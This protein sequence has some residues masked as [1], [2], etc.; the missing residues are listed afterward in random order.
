MQRR[1]S[2]FA[3]VSGVAAIATMGVGCASTINHEQA[4]RDGAFI[5]IKSGPDQAHAAMMGLRMA[6]LMS[7]DRDVLVYCDIDGIGLV[8]DDSPELK[9]EPFGSS[10]AMVDDLIARDVPVFACPG[11]LK[12]AGK[13]PDDLADG[14]RVAEKEAFF[15]FTRGRILTLDY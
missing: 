5:H 7:A 11:C 4:P 1:T 15:G 12:A 8:L 13:T 6:Q 9:M 3:A 10:R 14:V 2:R